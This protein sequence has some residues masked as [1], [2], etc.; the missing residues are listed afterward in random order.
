MRDKRPVDELSIEELERIL[1]IRRREERQKH[2]RRLEQQGRRI[3][4]GRSA[5]AP[6]PPAEVSPPAGAAA[7]L[8]G[9]PPEAPEPAGDAQPERSAFP[10]DD[11]PPRFEDDY[12]SDIPAGKPEGARP[13]K[14]AFWDMVWNR[15]LLVIEVLAVIGLFVIGVQMLQA[16][17][18]LQAETAAVQ[19]E[20]QAQAFAS[21]PTPSPTPEI[22]LSR[23][24][25]PSGH[26]PPAPGRPPQFNYDEIPEHLRPIVRQQMMAAEI[27]I[28]T[29][30]PES[31]VR[32][33]VPAINIDAPIVA[34]TD[35]EA[36]K[37]GVGHQPGTGLPG[38]RG[39]VVLSAHNDIYGE[40]FRYLDQL[41]VGDT[42]TIHTLTQRYTYVIREV[43][44]VRPQDVWVMDPTHN[45][46][47][48]LISCYPYQVDNQRIV[49][50]GELLVE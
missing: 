7:G 46:T 13:D 31:P 35:W 6:S 1:A 42:F 49:V 40:I 39:N 38:Q 28:P 33:E 17:Q 8:A 32:L 10:A 21:L 5:F 4:P 29:P 37:R 44:I 18:F 34:G 22:S 19:A 15:S 45:P 30:G 43:Q 3:V 26:M 36:L 24:V 50:F 41:A 16:L 47:A 25:L 20:A 14:S 2:L 12:R 11:G 27:A 9:E 23:I 48:T